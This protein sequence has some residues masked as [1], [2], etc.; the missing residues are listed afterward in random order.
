MD[1]IPYPPVAGDA[2]TKIEIKVKNIGTLSLEEALNYR[3]RINE[4]EQ[5]GTFLGKVEPKR[6][7]RL[8]IPYNFYLTS[9]KNKKP[10]KYKIYFEINYDNKINDANENNNVL[11]EVV[12]FVET[13]K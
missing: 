12:E 8:S 4:W 5:T 10:G 6:V 9:T 1:I 7:I 11:E 13:T 3:Y 2:R